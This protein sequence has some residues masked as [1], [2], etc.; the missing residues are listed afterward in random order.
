[1]LW[2]C[3]PSLFGRTQKLTGS[4]NI[5]VYM[6]CV[7]SALLY[8]SESWSTYMSQEHQLNIFHIPCFRKILGVTLKDRRS[9]HEILVQASL[10]SIYSLLSQRRL[11]WAGHVSHM[12]DSR[13]PKDIMYG[14]QGTRAAGRPKLYMDVLKRALRCTD[15]S[16]QTWEQ[17][18]T[19]RTT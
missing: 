8:G 6:T 16:I 5:I 7:L 2:P 14:E 15:I 10:P 12:Q 9:N 19:D 18:A 3:F 4:S 1:M 17:S 11:R 13:I